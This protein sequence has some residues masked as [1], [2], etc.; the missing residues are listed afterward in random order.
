MK[1][2]LSIV[3]FTIIL[4]S[5]VLL[6]N[7][8][9]ANSNVF[10]PPSQATNEADPLALYPGAVVKTQGYDFSKDFIFYQWA[11]QPTIMK[12][13][14]FDFKWLWYKSRNETYITNNSYPIKK[15]VSSKYF[16]I[17]VDAS[18]GSKTLKKALTIQDKVYDKLIREIEKLYLKILTVYGQPTDVD[19]DGKIAIVFHE[20]DAMKGKGGYFNESNVIEGYRNTGNMDII[21]VDSS[22]INSYMQNFNPYTITTIMHELQHDIEANR[23][24][25]S[26]YCYNEALSESTYFVLINNENLLRSADF[27]FGQ[28]KNGQYFFDWHRNGSL[29][30]ENYR[31]AYYFMYWLYVQAESEQ[32]IKDI[33][34][35]SINKPINYTSIAEAAGKNIKTLNKKNYNTVILYWYSANFHNEASGIYGYKNRANISISLS[36][37]YS[38]KVILKPQCAVYTTIDMFDKNKNINSVGAYKLS[39]N[40]RN[41]VLLFNYGDK[42]RTVYVN[43]YTS[44]RMLKSMVKSSEEIEFYDAVVYIDDKDGFKGESLPPE[45]D[46]IPDRIIIR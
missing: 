42:D 18:E 29:I 7:I 37:A 25:D 2:K 4:I 39:S 9:C 21:Y 5:L 3:I 43:P 33:C 27:S 46:D 40:G 24:Y 35:S 23:N 30:E 41:W 6:S 17:Y 12:Y 31:T 15:I 8:S 1:I 13:T 45:I 10:E 14:P 28:I 11:G 38:G 44:R 20:R 36:D 16:D 26:L 32:I 22:L 34:L 19:N